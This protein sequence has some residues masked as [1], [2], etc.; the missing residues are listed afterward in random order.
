MTSIIVW[1][2][3]SN[4]ISSKIAGK[5]PGDEEMASL[6]SLYLKKGNLRLGII[7]GVALFAFVFAI[8]IIMANTI[9]NAKNVTWGD[10]ILWAPWIYSFS[11]ANAFREEIWSRGL[12]MKRT[13]R[14]VGKHAAVVI[15][16]LPFA[17][18]H[19]TATYTPDIWFFVILTFGLGV[20]WG[21]LMQWTDSMISPVLSHAAIDIPIALSYFSNY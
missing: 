7:T 15:Q 2:K 14:Y 1:V 5:I 6:D 18:A 20:L 21:S 8:Q 4:K 9:Y 3:I 11:F 10:A 16:A 17:L 19:F 13:E 12:A